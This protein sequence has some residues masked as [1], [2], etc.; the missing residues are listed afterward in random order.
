MRER[1]PMF[2]TVPR[3]VGVASL[4]WPQTP[5]ISPRAI[6]TT[7]KSRKHVRATPAIHLNGKGA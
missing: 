1:P 2:E 6:S 5:H 3:T 4:S 7:I